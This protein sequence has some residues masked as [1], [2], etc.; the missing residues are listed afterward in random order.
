M[1]LRQGLLLCVLTANGWCGQ[2]ALS[3]NPAEDNGFAA[4]ATRN[5]FGLQ[6]ES[7]ASAHPVA[8][9]PPAKITPNGIMTI[10]GRSQVLFKVSAPTL[11]GQP[12]LKEQSYI[13]GEGERQDDIEVRKIDLKSA[14]ITVS[15]HGFIQ[16]LLLAA[17]LASGGNNASVNSPPP[18]NPRTVARR[19]S[20]AYLAAQ[21]A[22]QSQDFLANIGIVGT[23]SH[24]TGPGI[25]A[26]ATGPEPGDEPAAPAKPPNSDDS[27]PLPNQP[28]A[29]QIPNAD[30]PSAAT[31]PIDSGGA[32]TVPPQLTAHEI[33]DGGDVPPAAYH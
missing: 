19:L 26:L 9:A 29:N 6:H 33:V 31:P 32:N 24:F 20:A 28:T 12:P 11:P 4:I 7:S 16:D 3:A 14:V 23:P 2:I 27:Q 8:T 1:N 21:S 5:V 13:L 15:N 22:S 30:A 17:S 25:G 18:V 10:F